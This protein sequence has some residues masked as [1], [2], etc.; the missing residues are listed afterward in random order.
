MAR[1]IDGNGP[2]DGDRV[3]SSGGNGK[4]S[5]RPAAT[6]DRDRADRRVGDNDPVNGAKRQA[7]EKYNVLTITLIKN[8]PVDGRVCQE[9]HR[10]V[11][12]VVNAEFS[13]RV[14]IEVL[15]ADQAEARKYG[16]I[17]TP[18]VAIGGRTF[19][20]GEPVHR[21]RLIIWIRR[22]LEQP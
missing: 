15:F 9:T 19:S 22:E 5:T 6:N 18:V 20:M 1:L 16:I 21:D 3:G 2:D 8:A 11:E 17:A 7:D 14:A 13:G 12:E 4:R 10:L